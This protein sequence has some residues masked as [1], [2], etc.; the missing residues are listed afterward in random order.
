MNSEE[1]VKHILHTEPNVAFL[2][3]KITEFNAK[4]LSQT[5]CELRKIAKIPA[6]LSQVA[7]Q[8]IVPFFDVCGT[9]GTNGS[10]LN[11]STLVALCAPDL[12]FAVSK[13]GGRSASGKVGSLD[14]LE[15]LGLDLPHLF[16]NAAECLRAFHLCYL[17]AGLTYTPFA[18]YAAIRKSFGKPSVFN[19]LG[20]LLNPARPTHRIV[21]A[22]NKEVAKLIA[23][24][25]V[26]LKEPG[27]VVVSEDDEGFL[28]E[29][30][31]FGESSCYF[32]T[33]DKNQPQ[34]PFR[35]HKILLPQIKKSPATR[36]ELFSDGVAAA[37][38]LLQDKKTHEAMAAK[39][40][41]SYNLSLMGL[42]A[43]LITDS[44]KLNSHDIS[45]LAAPFLQRYHLILTSFSARSQSAVN[46]INQLKKTQATHSKSPT[47]FPCSEKI[48][49]IPVKIN[50][51]KS[52]PE[53][54]NAL[55]KKPDRI[56]NKNHPSL[57]SGWFF[58]EIK[59]KTPL[60]SFHQTLPLSDR[61]R[62]YRGAHAL[63]V[64]THEH[65]GG[66]LHLL[67]QVRNLTSQPILAKDF[68]KNTEPLKAIAA[69]GANGCLLL[70]DMVDAKT[71]RDQILECHNVGLMPFVESSWTDPCCEK[72][73]VRH[74][75]NTEL[76]SKYI[77]VFNSR[78][79]F[80]LEEGK[81]FRNQGAK[82]SI[83]A[84]G[85]ESASEI[86]TLLRC[87]PGV[88]VGS[89]LMKLNSEFEIDSFISAAT[90]RT[91][92]F[93]ACGA[94]SAE[95]IATAF[96]NGADWVGINLIPWSKRF[97]DLDSL[98]Q[99]LPLIKRESRRIVAV[100]SLQ[101][102]EQYISILSGIPILEQPYDVPLI[103]NSNGILQCSKT[104]YSNSLARILDN[105]RPGAGEAIEYPMPSAEEVNKPFL[106]AGGIHPGI[107]ETKLHEAIQKGWT[108]AGIDVATGIENSEP[109]RERG[110]DAQKI[111]LL[112][113]QLD[114]F[115]METQ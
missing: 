106:I 58:A 5:V 44:S 3:T 75:L 14:L 41:V 78:N 76:L 70:A 33:P 87:A 23:E 6:R 92:S 26:E 2:E 69:S 95:D 36:L 62:A 107:L 84:S 28:D 10:R 73:K 43:Q 57:N 91:L 34:I 85:F 90:K 21:G 54:F 109:Q 12:G 86:R 22:W 61:V 99:A 102:P 49:N 7:E 114:S 9:G 103:S 13:H 66:S 48:E 64:V 100:T 42:T 46:R 82:N 18:R 51:N 72:F 37:E 79:L 45:L 110:F 112:R 15:K 59:N 32:V 65:F 30:S 115:R 29:A 88:I 80:S 31:P 24:T 113:K 74:D 16:E 56:T 67:Q 8:L 94:R 60:K 27:C 19:L 1:L 4:E 52:G 35:I 83:L 55:L 11:T 47:Q 96:A 108:V 97:M 111:F 53:L 105:K 89:S 40:L 101:T 38:A 71:L 20:P 98:M 93:K 77:G 50:S 39:Q 81:S 104:F 17:G 63:S 68:I 25:L